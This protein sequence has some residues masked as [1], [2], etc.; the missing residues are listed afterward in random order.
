MSGVLDKPESQHSLRGMP[1]HHRQV[2]LIAHRG[3]WFQPQEKNSV[4]AFEAALNDGFGIETDVRDLGS[5]LVISHDIPN[6]RC[7][8][9]ESFLEQY[10][11]S[12]ANSTL[13]I[14]I[15][16]DGLAQE[17]KS[18]LQKYSVTNYFV[19]DMS[20]PDSLHYTKLGMTLYARRSEYEPESKQLEL[21][22]GIWMDGF[23]TEW[24]KPTDWAQYLAQE[25]GVCIVSPELHKRP[26]QSFWNELHTWLK[27]DQA[28]RTTSARLMLCTDFPR[29]F[30]EMLCR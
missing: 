23:H 3:L 30:R 28:H 14:N 11:R 2:E 19:F 17:L 4:G 7:Q 10:Q 18:W 6:A 16:S 8:T 25:K 5:Q 27:T 20:V 22:Q 15:K 13:A 9:L 21:A 12:N 29:E 26:H 24:F 1:K